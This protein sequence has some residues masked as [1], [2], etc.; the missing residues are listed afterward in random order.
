MSR[1]RGDGPGFNA[2]GIPQVQRNAHSWT[3]VA[4]VIAVNNPPPIG[5]SYCDGGSGPNTGPSGDGYSCGPWNDS[6]VAKAN[7]AFLKS[8]FTTDFPEYA[9]FNPAIITR[10]TPPTRMAPH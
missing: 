2:T 3:K 8:L 7:A 10:M 9:K 4:N 1:P 6:S 5:F